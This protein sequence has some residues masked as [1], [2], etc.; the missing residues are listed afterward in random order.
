M[1]PNRYTMKIFHINL[2]ELFDIIN[3]CVLI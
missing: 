3:V 2:M 1:I